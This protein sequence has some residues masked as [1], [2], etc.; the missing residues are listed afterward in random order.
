ENYILITCGLPGT[1]SLRALSFRDYG[2]TLIGPAVGAIA[3]KT[4]QGGGHVFN[5][6][7]RTADGQIVG[8]GGNQSDMVCDSLFDPAMLEYNWPAGYPVPRTGFDVLPVVT[9]A[10]R[11]RREIVLPPTTRLELPG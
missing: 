1:G 10:P 5:V 4:R 8:R 6:V 3:T 11:A 9:P 7:G 2:V